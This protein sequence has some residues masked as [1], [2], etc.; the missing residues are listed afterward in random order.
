MA[1][2]IKVDARTSGILNTVISCEW[3]VEYTKERGDVNIAHL[4]F[5]IT[6]VLLV[7]QNKVEIITC[8]EFFVYI[9][10]SRRQVEATKEQ[11]DWNGF[12]W[13]K[14]RL[15]ESKNNMS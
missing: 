1:T 3:N 2:T 10:E 7:D 13:K 8:A 4:L 11:A 6:S 14:M 5:E 15:D 12:A 9:S